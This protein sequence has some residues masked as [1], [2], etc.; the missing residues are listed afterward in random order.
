M[1]EESDSSSRFLDPQSHH[2]RLPTDDIYPV[3]SIYGELQGLTPPPE[4][5]HRFVAAG[6][7]GVTSAKFNPYLKPQPQPHGGHLNGYNEPPSP[8]RTE[9]TSS[10]PQSSPL[11]NSISTQGTDGSPTTPNPNTPE[12]YAGME[13][14]VDISG[15]VRVWCLG[16]A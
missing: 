14:D 16:G 11:R 12:S 10:P 5:S 2:T 8:P 3:Q 15:L 13:N 6:G 1:N 7:T 4:E 9:D